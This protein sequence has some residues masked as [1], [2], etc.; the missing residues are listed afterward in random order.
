M[1]EMEWAVAQAMDLHTKEE[2]FM[3]KRYG[4]GEGEGWG[5]GRVGHGMAAKPACA[6][7]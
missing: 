4:G 1:G 2:N 7:R 5:G 3:G 6:C